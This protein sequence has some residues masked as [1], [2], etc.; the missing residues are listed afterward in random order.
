MK[1]YEQDP[2]EIYA[3]TSAAHSTL[4]Y[5]N[6]PEA[7]L[8][9]LALIPFDSIDFETWYYFRDRIAYAAQASLM[10]GD[11]EGARG[12]IEYFPVGTKDLRHIGLTLRTYATLNDSMAINKLLRELEATGPRNAHEKAMYQLC[13]DLRLI[14]NE[15]LFKYYSGI[16]WGKYANPSSMI[17]HIMYLQD[18]GKLDSARSIISPVVKDYPNSPNPVRMQARQYIFEN[19]PD[20]ARSWI[21]KLDSVVPEKY[22]YGWDDYRQSRLYALAGDRETALFELRQAIAEG[23]TF[24]AR[25]LDNDPDLKMLFGLPEY[26]SITHPLKN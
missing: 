16:L 26:L 18:Y 12:F 4:Q 2:K 21:I 13:R 5:V 9:I 3:N 19:K 8:D 7:A 20:S 10:L 11:A 24:N 6:E 17:S 25:T 22:D 15:Q 14:G 1:F 23:M